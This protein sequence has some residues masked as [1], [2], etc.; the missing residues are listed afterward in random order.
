[1]LLFWTSFGHLHSVTD[2][3]ILTK[4]KWWNQSPCLPENLLEDMEILTLTSILIFQ[5]QCCILTL[6]IT[7]QIGYGLD[8]PG[9]E[10]RWGRRFSAPVQTGPGAQPASCT[11]GTGSFLEVKSG[12]GVTLTPHPVLVP[13][14]WKGTALPLLPP[15]AVR[16]VQSRSACTRVHFYYSRSDRRHVSY[17]MWNRDLIY[18]T[19]LLQLILSLFMMKKSA[20]NNQDQS[21]HVAW[22]ITICWK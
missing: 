2:F 12:R 5:T 22:V 4:C 7:E 16:P 15:W 21:K 17:R 6:H 14:S 9:I 18:L 3:L 20:E 8:V 13:W 11:M 1:M 10:S 19:H